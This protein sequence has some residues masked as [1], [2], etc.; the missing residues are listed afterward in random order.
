[1]DYVHDRSHNL[2]IAQEQNVYYDSSTNF[3]KS[4][5]VYGRPNLNFGSIL[6]YK[7]PTNAGSIYDALLVNIER[8]RWRNV[9]GSIAY[10]FAREKSNNVFNNPYAIA[11]DW[12]LAADDQRHTLNP[13]LS[14]QYKWG[15]RS[16]LLFHYGSGAHYDV[17][18]GTQPTGMTQSDPVSL[19]NRYFC[20]GDATASVCSS[21]INTYNNPVHNHLDSATGL[22]IT[23]KNQLTGSPIVRLDANLAKELLIGDR[24]RV[25][26][27]IEAFNVLNH[28]NYGSYTTSITSKTFG[29]PL[30]NTDTAYWPRTLQFSAKYSF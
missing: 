19:T 16:A 28:A 21:K 5:S 25:T 23:D 20:G 24:H 27:Q 22:D 8:L 12:G 4:P 17:T 18:A 14:Y 10:T 7:T 11:G 29:S 26:V 3:N 13:T 15:L 6:N 1:V 9:S 30:T 2:L